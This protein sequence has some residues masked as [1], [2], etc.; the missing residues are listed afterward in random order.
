MADRDAPSR[1]NAST[2]D[3][4]Y[5]DLHKGVA[6]PASERGHADHMLG[7]YRT[8]GEAENW[9]AT[10]DARNESWDEE[11]E[12]WENWGDGDAADSDHG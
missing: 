9:R 1:T 6:V 12:R 7:P 11:D 2:D 8:K 3:E 5:F 4:W 10:K